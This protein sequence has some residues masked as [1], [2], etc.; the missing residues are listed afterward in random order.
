M[1]TMNSKQSIEVFYGIL[2]LLLL[3][4]ILDYLAFSNLYEMPRA[5]NILP[6][7]R[8]IMIPVYFIILGIIGYYN[9]RGVTTRST[10]FSSNFKKIL[11]F[12][13]AVGSIGTLLFIDLLNTDLIKLLYPVLFV[14]GNFSVGA[15]LLSYTSGVGEVGILT[16]LGSEKKKSKK[17]FVL[18]SHGGFINVPNPSRGVLVIG[19]AG[20]G[21]SESIAEPLIYHSVEDGYTGFIYDFKFPTLANSVY[22]SIKHFN[23]SGIKFYPVSFSDLTKSY[24]FNPLDPRFL[25]S[26]TYVDEYSWALYTNLDKE[27]IKKGGFFPD[28]AAGVL[29]AVIW[30][31]KKNHPQFCTLPHVINF[32]LNSSDK[33]LCNMLMKDMETMGMVKPIKEAYEK[34]AFEQLAGITGTLT[35]QLQKIN[36]PEINWVL[37]GDDFTIDLNNPNDPKLIVLG[38]HPTIRT[39]LS[40]IIAFISTVCLKIMN[41]QGKMKSIAIIDEGPTIYIPNLDEIPA[42]ARSNKLSVVYM[43]QDFSQM[44]SMYG[45]DKRTALVANLATQFYGNVSELTTA[46]YVSEMIGKEYR[47]I[48]SV[49]TGLSSSDSGRSNSSGKSYSEQQREILK[50]QEL[51]SFDPGEFVGKLVETDITYFKTKMKRVVDFDKS[52]KMLELPEFVEDFMMEEKEVIE[53]ETMVRNAENTPHIFNHLSVDISYLSRSFEDK[54]LSKDDFMEKLKIELTKYKAKEKRD[55][56]LKENFE[57]IHNEVQE[58]IDLYK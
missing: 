30:Y 42:T 1:K 12:V 8:T 43:A 9:M 58:I 22:S 57:K 4:F 47:I 36:T 37:S 38:S 45:K 39:A 44:D 23:T 33:I 15:L 13:I 46:K 51:F 10:L 26:Q 6:K 31:F 2:V 54:K 50:P 29:K 14:S 17:G 28:S 52:Y 55:K 18:N 56:I 32:I 16:E 21:K 53:I 41:Q 40:P 48:E 34:N 7:Y 25:E 20:A 27:A 5:K 19:G 35:M 3:F 24:R 49:N 11:L